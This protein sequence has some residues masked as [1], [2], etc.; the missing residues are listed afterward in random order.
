MTQRPSH[1]RE[2][3][4]GWITNTA[5]SV[6]DFI[7]IRWQYL[8]RRFG[9]DGIPRI[10]PYIGYANEQRVWLHGR[11]LTNPP[12]ELPG[13]D[14]RWWDNLANTYQRFASDEVP[15]CRVEIRIGESRHQVTT[16]AEGYFYVAAEHRFPDTS[17]GLW[18]SAAMQIV[19]NPKIAPED[20]TVTS[21]ILTPGPAA[22]FGVISD[23]D[24]TI[25]HTGATRL[26]TM[27]KLTFLGNARTRLPL[28]GVAAFYQA[29]QGFD[30][31]GTP[32]A[33]PIFYVSSSPWNLFDLL[34]DFLE[35]NRIPMGPLLLRD[36]GFDRNKFL[37]EGH[38]H[39][40]EKTRNILG[41]YP[42]LPFILVGDSGQEDARLYAAAAEEFGD[43]IRVI[44]IRDVDPDV[45]TTKHDELCSAV[46]RA[47]K[48]SVAMHVIRDSVAA[49][50]I[51]A[52][53]GLIDAATD[54]NIRAA[55]AQDLKRQSSSGL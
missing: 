41:A 26:L 39:K 20:S 42:N 21:K 30:K 32:S 37:S 7:D 12:A 51:A 52:S 27:A 8:K 38:D 10:Q 34:E 43:R 28:P 50:Q 1:W 24:D 13:D 55:T 53:L 4:K 3:L 19:D 40:L 2:D 18:S 14:D 36:L 29:L 16:D 23:V 5:A 47:Q 45:P 11:V 25:L 44:F 15:N 6:D 46:E 17:H 49:A 54:E 33:N 48:C 9:W 35:L 31:Q 22:Q